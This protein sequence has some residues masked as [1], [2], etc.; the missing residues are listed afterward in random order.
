MIVIDGRF[1]TAELSGIGRYSLGLLNGLASIGA[2]KITV[3][4]G[5]EA[6]MAAS[7]RPSTSIDHVSFNGSPLSPRSQLSLPPMLRRLGARAFHSPYVTAPL[8]ARSI[9][10]VITVHD[11]IP[12]RFPQGLSRAWKVRVSH[13]WNSWCRAQYRR[14]AKLV[15]VSDFSKRELIEFARVPP[16]K[17]VRIHNGV[18]APPPA[19]AQLV[20]ERFGVPADAPIVSYIGRH[21]PYKNVELLVRAFPAVVESV[22]GA[23]LVIGGALDHRYPE[24]RATAEKGPARRSILFTGYLD[25]V[26][27]ASLLRASSVFAFA[28][29]YEGFGL[30]PLEAM[31]AGVPVVSS[32]ATSLP[33]VLAD[34]ATL[35]SPDDVG[36]FSRAIIELLRDGRLR[37]SRIE[38]GLRQAAKFT[39]RKSAEEHLALYEQVMRE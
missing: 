4:G 7:L 22:S 36:G 12:Q 18:V 37:A 34:A 2:A 21:D 20:R 15:T 19:S 13:L 26:L 17:V 25:E 16:Q 33:E 14:A 1:I 11:L 31:A 30:P 23:F 29:R 3:L 27:R 9:P 5:D 24:A 28:S 35:V 6:A 8:L 39:W 32:D 38:A 10:C